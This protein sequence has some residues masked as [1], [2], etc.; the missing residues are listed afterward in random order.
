MSAAVQSIWSPTKLPKIAYGKGC[1]LYDTD[2]K[3]YIDGSGGP[4]VFCLGHGNEEVNQ[5]IKDQL[6]RIAH[7]YRYTF[8][9]DPLEELTE[10]VAGPAAATRPQPD[11]LRLQRLGGGGILP[12]DR[13]AISQR[14]RR[15]EP[16]ALHRPRA[17]LAR[18]Y[19]GRARRL[20]L[21]RPARCPSRARW[22]RRACSRRSTP[23]ARRPA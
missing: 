4:A 23:T 15:A 18:Q 12:Q 22:W 17:L 9:S 1:Y 20:R 8:T 16:P 19:A 14:P 10:M 3:Q 2:G 21:S 6:D 13:A 11:D 7:G 5:A